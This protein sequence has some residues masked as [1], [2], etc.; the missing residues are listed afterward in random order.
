MTPF[1]YLPYL[2]ALCI[3]LGGG[4]WVTQN[5]YEAVI[6]KAATKAAED[7][8]TALKDS[9]D[10]LKSAQILADKL[11][12][13]LG[14]AETALNQTTLEKTREISRI[15]TGHVCFNPDLTRL[16][17]SPGD[18]RDGDAGTVSDTSSPSHAKDEAV[19][20]AETLTLTDT[21]IAEWIANAQG[22]YEICR[23]RLSKLIDFSLGL[24]TDNTKE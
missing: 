18:Q 10:R 8:A 1:K 15:A 20:S 2:I 3:G 16:L 22:Q 11:S 12:V 13:Q 23:T 5:H 21:D 4:Y 24:T 9:G 17:N 6:A 14:Y 19:A 7:K